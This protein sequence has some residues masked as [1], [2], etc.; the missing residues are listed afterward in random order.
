M[1][2]I[3]NQSNVKLYKLITFVPDTLVTH[4]IHRFLQALTMAQ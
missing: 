2:F 1:N 3:F 4:N